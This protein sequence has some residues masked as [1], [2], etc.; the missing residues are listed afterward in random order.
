MP[1]I[2][3][4]NDFIQAI[5]APPAPP[6]PKVQGFKDPTRKAPQWGSPTSLSAG[7]AL[8]RT[9]VAGSF[10]TKQASYAP[11][12]RIIEDIG[13]G[14]PLMHD[15][16]LTKEAFLPALTTAA[17]GLVAVAKPTWGAIKGLGKLV[18]PSGQKGWLGDTAKGF[19]T[20]GFKGSRQAA[21][22]RRQAA[23]VADAA[24]KGKPA[25]NARQL[26]T[27][28]L[29]GKGELVGAGATAS[30]IGSGALDTARTAKNLL[31]PGYQP[32]STAQMSAQRQNATRQFRPYRP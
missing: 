4:P 29:G 24:A 11:E 28:G 15:A 2:K 20:G 17:R 14:S 13:L 27:A 6:K 7:D 18:L 26:A 16:L 3:T 12:Y 19:A 32:P 25:P 9:D 10:P 5:T 21:V 23:A 8:T 30:M 1:A 22:S 31:T